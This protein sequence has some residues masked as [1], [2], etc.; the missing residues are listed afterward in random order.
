MGDP[1]IFKNKKRELFLL[2]NLDHKTLK[3][4]LDKKIYQIDL[5]EIILNGADI[6]HNAKFLTNFIGN[7]SNY[8]EKHIEQLTAINI[9]GLLRSDSTRIPNRFK[10]QDASYK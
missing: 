10:K 2:S 5:P 8:L 4:N 9:N 6:H 1:T 7:D 3:I